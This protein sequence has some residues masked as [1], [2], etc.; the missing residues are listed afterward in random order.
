VTTVLVV[1]LAVVVALLVVLVTGLLRSHAA[2]LRALHDLG[3]DIN[4]DS[5]TLAHGAERLRPDP[6]RASAAAADVSGL[7]PHGDAA[8]FTI[9]GAERPTLLVFLTSGCSTCARF[10]YAL[11][12]PHGVRAP[13]GARLIAVTKGQEAERPARLRMLLPPN[14]PVVMS[15]RAWE[16]Y[17]VPVAPYFAYVDGASGTVVGDGPADTWEDVVSMCERAIVGRRATR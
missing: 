12:D 2:T 1:L 4:P 14:V 16:S 9:V 13:G 17:D 6:R 8:A 11:A 5:T 10:W 7:T 3:V 15:S